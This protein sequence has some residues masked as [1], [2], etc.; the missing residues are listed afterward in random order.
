MILFVTGQ[1]QLLNYVNNK[2]D[3]VIMNALSTRRRGFR[4][5]YTFT[6][7]LLP[8]IEAPGGEHVRGTG[9]LSIKPCE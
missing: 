2:R 3:N 1:I 6:K 7:R 4:L 5:R 9:K 8:V